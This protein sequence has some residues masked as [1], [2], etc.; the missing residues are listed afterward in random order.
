MEE[1]WR[2][3]KGYEGKYQVSNL[4]RVKSLNYNRTKKEKVLDFKPSKAGYII[5]RLC[6]EGKSKPYQVHRLVALHFIDNP[7]NY[8]QVNHK[9]E[10]KTNNCVDNLEWCTQK[11]NN[12][13]GTHNKRVSESQKGK[14]ISEETKKKMSKNH[15]DVSG[16]KNPASRKVQ[17]STTGKKFNCIKEAAEYYHINTV[18]IVNCC[19]GKQKY[20][21]THSITREKLKWE[22][23]D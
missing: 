10:N 2:D 14:V 3:I 19:R 16:S 22:Y 9:D 15:A 18:N 7:N 8:P 6:R 13:Y 20:A 23:I 17:C 5:V 11:Y 12:N 21:G 1:I 4:G